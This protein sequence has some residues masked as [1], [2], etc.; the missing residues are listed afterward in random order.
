MKQQLNEVKRMQKLAGIIYEA[1][2]ASELEP[3]KLY[4]FSGGK[5]TLGP[6]KGQPVEGILKFVEQ[7]GDLIYF[8]V[9]EMTQDR[10]GHVQDHPPGSRF[11]TSK[12]ILQ[13]LTPHT[14]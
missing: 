1:I 10:S 11:I 9:V 7:K 8:E 12:D 6:S 14:A 13:Y 4:K 5:F 2:E 3:G